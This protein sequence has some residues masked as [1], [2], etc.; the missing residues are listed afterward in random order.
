M[1]VHVLDEGGNLLDAANLHCQCA[2]RL[3]GSRTRNPAQQRL[4]EERFVG[5]APLRRAGP[6]QHIVR[7]R[8]VVV[9]GIRSHSARSRGG[10]PPRTRP[11]GC[12]RCRTH[13]HTP[14]TRRDRCS[15]PPLSFRPS[16]NCGQ[17]RGGRSTVPTVSARCPARGGRMRQPRRRRA[18]EI[19]AIR[20][21]VA[22]ARTPLWE[23]GPCGRLPMARPCGPAPWERRRQW[24]SPVEGACPTRR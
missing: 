21:H 5:R 23:A 6:A 15:R 4:Q 24:E 11:A 10:V 19:H 18:A 12:R 2:Q 7:H 1:V 16:D 9:P 14:A 22:R 13:R 17:A 8:T 20:L 3:R